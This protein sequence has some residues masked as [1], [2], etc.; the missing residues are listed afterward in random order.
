MDERQS[1][2]PSDPRGGVD[3]RHVTRRAAV[4]TG[5]AGLCGVAGLAGCLGRSGQG[6]GDLRV[7]TLAVRG[8]PGDEIPV[9]PNGR[10]VLLDFFATWCAS[11]KTQM[12]NFRELAERYPEL[13]LL[14][15]TWEDDTSAVRNFWNRHRGTWPVA[16]D[17]Q[18]RTGQAFGV[19]MIPTMLLFDP[20]GEEVWRDT[21]LATV[22][23]MATAVERARP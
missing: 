23:S 6:G 11:C 19:E 18:I 3:S 20:D 15:I 5:F 17:P 7:E 1:S 16:T 13:H 14:S 22:E 12:P 9:R 8:S 21:G 4:R 10:V 2:P